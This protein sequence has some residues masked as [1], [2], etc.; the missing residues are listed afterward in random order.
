MSRPSVSIAPSYGYGYGFGGY[1]PFFSPFSPFAAAPRVY[2]GPGVIGLSRGPSI[3]DFLF[4]LFMVVAVQ[5][6]LKGFAGESSVFDSV[7]STATSQSVLGP[8]TSVVQLSVALEVPNRDDRN[9]ILS[10]LDR[11]SQTARTDS[12]VGIQNLTSQV[13]LEVLRR[14]S[15]IVSASSANKH[16]RNQDKALREFQTTSIKERSKFE[17]ETVNRYGGVDYSGSK[18]FHSSPDG[19]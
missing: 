13:A 5:N 16:F 6:V 11:I 4:P 1:S 9:S 2:G 14:K 3:F 12:R 18:S 15:S 19:N 7:G 10:V 8:G 17:T